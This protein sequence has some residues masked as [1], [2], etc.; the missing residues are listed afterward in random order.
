M[1]NSYFAVI[2]CSVV[3][4]ENF[5]LK[6]LNGYMMSSLMIRVQNSYHSQILMLTKLGK[7]SLIFQP[8]SIEG[9]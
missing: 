8:I 1:M 5:I 7:P 4:L 6:I 2:P 3:L 9:S